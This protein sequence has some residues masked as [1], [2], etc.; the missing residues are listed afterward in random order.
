MARFQQALSAQ[1]DDSSHD[2]LD[3]KGGC[4]LRTL[5]HLRKAT[6]G[7][8]T[9]RGKSDDDDD[10]D[11][12]SLFTSLIDFREEIK[13]AEARMV[14]AHS[15]YESLASLTAPNSALVALEN[16]RKLLLGISADDVGPLFDAIEKTHELLNDVESSLNDCARSIDG[17]LMSTLE[18]MAFT[19]I[20]LEVVDGIIADWNALARK[21]GISVSGSSHSMGIFYAVA[22]FI[23]PLLQPYS[24]PNC[25]MSMREELDG[26]V[27]AIKLL[28][29]A[30]ETE[31]IAR[32]DYSRACRVL[33]DA[34]KEV[35]MKLSQS[36]SNILPSLGLDG[37]TLHVQLSTRSGGFE[38]PYYGMEAVGVDIAEFQLIHHNNANG[39]ENGGGNVS[40]KLELSSGASSGEKSRVLLAIETALPGSIG[41]TCSSSAEHAPGQQDAKLPLA[42]IYDEIDAHVGGRAAVTMAKLLSDQSRVR[43]S[44]DRGRR[45]ERGSQIIA[46]THSASLAAIADRHIV[47]ERCLN[48]GSNSVPVRTYVVDGSSRRREIARMASGDLASDEAEKFAE[49]LIRDAMLHREMSSP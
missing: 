10:H 19:G 27:E 30:K 2:E 8:G 9:Q 33:S 35:A 28:P 21:H 36:V 12:D 11:D 24:L 47:V 46:I 1:D 15:A 4:I 22:C 31:N 25:H 13:A 29:E 3:G 49:A 48:R 5:R 17:S 18:N 44:R 39:V 42:I 7:G 6:W 37:S 45:S 14:S 23:N 26:N 43:R 34:R 16:V 38:E 40:S 41:S 32:A 20:P